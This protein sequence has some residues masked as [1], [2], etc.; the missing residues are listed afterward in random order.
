MLS[1]C[2]PLFVISFKAVDKEDL[3]EGLMQSM[4][5]AP[6]AMCRAVATMLLDLGPLG[7]LGPPPPP[8][9]R[10]F[11]GTGTALGGSAPPASSALGGVRHILERAAAAERCALCASSLT[12][13]E[14]VLSRGTGIDVRLH[15]LRCA[16]SARW[17]AE[18]PLQPLLRTMGALSQLELACVYEQLGSDAQRAAG[19]GAHK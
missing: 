18:V 6:R 3:I 1:P 15:H 8:V 5:P 17:A 16:A 12:P 14:L 11:T 2:Q 4:P 13:G 10:P 19:R 9:F 7:K